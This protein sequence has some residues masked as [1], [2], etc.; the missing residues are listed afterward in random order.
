MKLMNTKRQLVAIPIRWFG[1]YDPSVVRSLRE[2]G[3]R[4]KLNT[5]GKRIAGRSLAKFIQGAV[6][7]IAGTEPYTREIFSEARDLRVIS[8]VGSGVDNI[9]IDYA[10]QRKIKV[11]VTSSEWLF[12]AVAEHALTLMLAVLKKVTIYDQ[13]VRQ[14][15]FEKLPGEMLRGKT[16]G[17]VGFGRIG[18]RTAKLCSCF[19]AKIL[20]YDPYVK[21]PRNGRYVFVKTIQ[22]LLKKSDIVSIH[23]PY[24][25]KTRKLINRDKLKMMKKTAVLINTSRGGIVDEDALYLALKQK[26]ISGAALDVFTEEPYTGPLRE[27]DNVV[28]TP[29]V[30][31]HTVTSRVLMEKEAVKNLLDALKTK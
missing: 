14:G 27:L 8:R 12:D 23:V 26:K 18:R 11:C 17:I 13:N 22:D 9:D 21:P 16:V 7:V 29:H 6:G 5:T 31:S 25:E 1:K 30:A 10:K 19:G 24:S 3:F 2:A 15:N 28:L 4:V 20:V